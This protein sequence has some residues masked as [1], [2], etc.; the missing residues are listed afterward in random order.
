[1]LDLEAHKHGQLKRA[2][3]IQ[4]DT[5]L[6][7]IF[8]DV[9]TEVARLRRPGDPP[10]IPMHVPNAGQHLVDSLFELRARERSEPKAEAIIATRSDADDQAAGMLQSAW[11]R[12][13]TEAPYIRDAL[14]K[15]C[16]RRDYEEWLGV[17]LSDLMPTPLPG[18]VSHDPPAGFTVEYELK[19]NLA[20]M[21]LR[22]AEPEERNAV[23]QLMA[24]RR[25]KAAADAKDARL[26]AVEAKLEEIQG[27]LDH[28]LEVQK[29][30][31]W[32]V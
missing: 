14:A 3:F 5:A 13:Q 17:S 22:G 27:Q 12:Y 7:A 16:P 15:L 29:K 30:P 4:P 25:V 26:A 31:S 19:V 8:A 2:R 28:I 11:A 9:A 10:G 23:P 1:M 6:A 20:Y 24:Q 21:R 32:P 18:M